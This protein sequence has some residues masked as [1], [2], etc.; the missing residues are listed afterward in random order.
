MNNFQQ[1]KY[2]NKSPTDCKK[3]IRYFKVEKKNNKIKFLSL[4]HWQTNTF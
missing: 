3:E 1:K 2:K 4:N